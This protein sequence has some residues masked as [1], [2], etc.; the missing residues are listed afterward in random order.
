MSVIIFHWVHPNEETGPEIS[1]IDYRQHSVIMIRQ[2]AS[3]S[4]DPLE[5]K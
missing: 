3:C 2:L 5:D 1:I 4:I